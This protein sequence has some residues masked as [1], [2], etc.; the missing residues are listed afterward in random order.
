M[1][2]FSIII[3]IY[4]LEL[5]IEDA[6][7]S[8][9]QQDI[10]FE[11]N[12][13]LILVNDGSTDKSEEIC[14]RYAKLYPD[15]IIYIKQENQ[16]VSSARNKGMDYVTGKYMEFLDGDDKLSQD[17]LSKVGMFF[18]SVY[19]YT[20]VVVIPIKY[21]E[22][23]TG[24]C[25]T[26]F[27]FKENKVINLLKEYKNI[28]V[29]I[30]NAFMKTSIKES[31]KFK[32]T[33][34]WSEDIEF[35]NRLLL[36]KLTLGLYKDTF[37]FCRVRANQSSTVQTLYTTKSNYTQNIEN[38]HLHLI[39]YSKNEKGYIPKFIQYTVMY[40]IKGRIKQL[41]IARKCLD[42]NELEEYMN[43]IQEVLY[44]IEDRM[45]TEQMD[46]SVELKLLIFK[47]KYGK[48][49]EKYLKYICTSKIYTDVMFKDEWIYS[50]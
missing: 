24:E 20:D 40:L 35:I 43:K 39:K 19:D 32:E 50:T 1:F 36:K 2:K 18:D 29:N 31:F 49:Y 48:N 10:G 17:T 28:Q 34:N 15:N 42:I 45:I 41:D 47:L 12:V 46:C 9:I 37:Y 38:I 4:N 5:Y 13:Q 44:Y 3:P 22:G 7:Q 16:G 30:V 27:R 21:F 14:K 33:I 11:E 8:I 23:R 25:G 26:N 6:I